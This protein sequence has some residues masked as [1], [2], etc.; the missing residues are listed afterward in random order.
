MLLVGRTNAKSEMRMGEESGG[1]MDK[2][3]C[4]CRSAALSVVS[5]DSDKDSGLT[6]VGFRGKSSEMKRK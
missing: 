3:V 2:L 1:M 4:L 6:M 5:L